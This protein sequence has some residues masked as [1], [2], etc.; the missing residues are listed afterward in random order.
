M[1]IWSSMP[2]FSDISGLSLE[3]LGTLCRVA[4]AGSIVGA[5][6]GDPNKQ[7]Q[8]SRQIKDLEAFMGTRL[9]IRKGKHLQVTETGK[10]LALMAN[11]FFQGLEAIR[12]TASNEAEIIR[13]G[14]GES[15]FRWR[16]FPK[17][18]EIQFSSPLVKMDFTTQQTAK[19]VECVK[20]GSLDMAIV[21]SNACD[22]S[23]ASEA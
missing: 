21:R 3:R 16:V 12:V 11:S 13:I 22:E 14:G 8:F 18:K 17:L 20:D 15:V 5:A 19:A 6:G 1:T 9:F 10:N 2:N 4:E 23:L 7:S